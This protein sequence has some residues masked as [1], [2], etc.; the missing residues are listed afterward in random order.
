[1]LPGFTGCNLTD[2][3]DFFMLNFTVGPVMSE[4]DVLEE[5]G[6]SAPYFR[7]PEF[8]EVM[9][10]N[11]KLM[12]EFLHAPKD[13][14][15]I[16]LTSSGTGAM[17]SC[18]MNLLSDKDKVLVINGGSFGQRFVEMCQLHNRNYTEIK[19]EFG[20]Q[21]KKEQLY[22]Y[23]G[24]CYTAFLVNMGETSSGVLYDMKL[25]SEFCRKNNIFLIIDAISTF[26][27]DEIDM[28]SLNAG[29]VIT[30]SQ[31][32]LSVHPG[33]SVVALSPAAINRVEENPEICMYLSMKEAL[34]N[35]KRGQTPWTPAVTTLLEIN[36]KLNKI[37]LMGGVKV[38]RN[39][40]I[41]RAKQFRD[42]IKT[43]PFEFVSESM[44]NTVTSLH[45]LNVG[46]K[47]IIETM[48]NDYDIWICPNGGE[49]ADIVFRVGHIGYI[50]ED[51][52]KKLMNAFSDM[53]KRGLLY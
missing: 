22:Q 21:V 53:Q 26:I 37:K 10:Q 23:D 3:E 4:P 31:K 38:E 45:P 14:R 35:G 42:F 17:E 8:S 11:E 44:S 40:I 29:A 15:C 9:F 28:T 16:F 36:R 39:E 34:D 43:L 52:N 18:V 41:K 19:T 1:M 46:A 24:K 13:A 27:A 20:K 51:N 7:T 49:K 30:G 12:L 6:K 5:S 50:T 2:N 33:I 48:K 25:I 47:S 32:A